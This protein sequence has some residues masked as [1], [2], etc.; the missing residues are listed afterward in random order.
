MPSDWMLSQ[1][2]ILSPSKSFSSNS[3][4]SFPWVSADYITLSCLL[5][6]VAR[7]IISYFL[8]QCLLLL[9]CL[10]LKQIRELF[11]PRAVVSTNAT[12]IKTKLLIAENG[13]DEKRL[14]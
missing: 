13:Q 4:N 3:S 8:I 1:I 14:S 7:V 9:S 5:L 10:A 6:N 12:T 11:D 2:T